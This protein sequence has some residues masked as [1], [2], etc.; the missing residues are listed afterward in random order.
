MRPSQTPNRPTNFRILKSLRPRLLR[1]AAAGLIATAILGTSGCKSVPFSLPKPS[2]PKLA[3]PDLS[4]LA[5]WKSENLVAK[6]GN[7]PKPP[8]LSFDS[9]PIKQ[10]V[11]SSKK[12]ASQEIQALRQ[13]IASTKAQLTEPIREP[14]KFAAKNAAKKLASN[15]NL[16]LGGSSS[17]NELPTAGAVNSKITQAQRDFQAALASSSKTIGQSIGDKTAGLKSAANDFSLPKSVKSAKTN[18]DDSLMAVNKSL[19]NAKGK[20]ASA[21]KDTLASSNTDNQLS[22]FEQRLKNAANKAKTAPTQIASSGSSSKSAANA[23]GGVAPPKPL[24]PPAT[25]TN[26][27]LAGSGTKIAQAPATPIATPTAPAT[28]AVSA[29]VA[30]LKAQL[31][32]MRLEQEK[33]IQ[34]Q[35]LAAAQPATAFQ[36]PAAS[37]TNATPVTVPPTTFAAREFVADLTARPKPNYPEMRPS[38]AP[39]RTASSANNVLSSAPQNVLRGNFSPV[40]NPV[41]NNTPQYPSQAV[42]STPAQATPPTPASNPNSQYPSTPYNSYGTPANN[43]STN[44]APVPTFAP[45]TK[46]TQVSFQEDKNSSNL[47]IKASTPVEPAQKHVSEVNI[48]DAVLKG[49]SNY[50]PGTVHALR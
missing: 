4:K 17:R 47:V 29:E 42:G 34:Q 20:L 39:L 50:A 33:L 44:T 3:A 37:A 27:A 22:L 5:F 16:D 6:K 2:L 32:Q 8:S 25:P 26:N 9:S 18:V 15:N 13:E 12:S 35:K 38:N 28:A 7:L 19:Y 14:Y 41:A 24:A 36:T 49:T 45:S 48:P 21:A 31:A 43:F 46:N 23:F 1:G 10:A 11:A 40:T 30:E